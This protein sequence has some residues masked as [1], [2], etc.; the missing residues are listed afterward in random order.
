[1]V[2][3][4]YTEQITI[5]R[6]L[7][8]LG[9]GETTTTIK[10]PAA[11]RAGSVTHDGETYDYIVDAYPS[12]GTIDVRIEGF[13]LVANGENK[14][15]GTTRFA[16]VF[17]R[18]IHG[19]SA[20]LYS[21]TVKNFAGTPDYESW[22]IVI[23][24]DSDLSIDDNDVSGF[25]RDGIDAI[26]D[27]GA[28]ADPNVIISHNT[29]IGSAAPLNGIYI[30]RGATGTISGNTVTDLT[31][32]S[33]WAA[34][35]ILIYNSD[36]ITVNDSNHVEN[37]HY[38]LDLL[39]SDGSTVSGN[40]LQDNVAFHIGLDN[41]DNNEVSGNTITGTLA[42]TEDKA[43]GL[44]NGSTGNTIGGPTPADGNS[45]TMAAIPE[46]FSPRKY[47]Y[48]VY[49]VGSVG[50]GNNTIQYNNLYGGTRAVQIDGG[51][52]GITTISDNTI[53]NISP[54]FAGIYLNGGSAIISRN[55]L[56]NT[57]R[58]MEWWG[59][60][61]V[62]V[63]NN[64]IDGATFDGINCGTF[65]GSITI[66][67]NA[68]YS[69]TGLGVH[70]RTATLIDASGNW[71]G[72]STPAGVAAEVSAN[73][74][75]TPWLGIGTDTD[76][77]TP[78]FQGDLSTLWVDDSSPQAGAMGR[79]E[80]G[81]S[82]VTSSTVYIAPGIYN[83][84]IT[85]DDSTP[86]DLTLV[87]SDPGNRPEI[88]GGVLFD[89]DTNDLNSITLRS[90]VLKGDADPSTR[91]AIIDMNN[92]AAVNDFVMDN[93]LLD[94]ENVAVNPNGADGRFGIVGNKFGGSFSIT[95]SEFKN[96]LGWVVMDMDAAYS[97]PPVG[98][99]ELPL[100]TVTF[101]D[102]SVH[103][104]NGSV[105]LRGNHASKTS[106]VNAN[107]NIWDN[108]GGNGGQTGIHWAALEV[109]NAVQ[110]NVQDN[111]IGNVQQGDYGEGQALQF[112]NVDVLNVQGNSITNNY[113]GIYI[114]SDGVGG[115]YCGASGCPVPGGFISG[116]D[117]MGN[118]DYGVK[119][120]AAAAG[121]PLN[122]ELN[123]WGHY[124]GPY[125]PTLN[126]GGIGNSVSDNVDFIPWDCYDYP[127]LII[128]LDTELFEDRDGGGGNLNVLDVNG[129]GV[130]GPGDVLLG[131][132]LIEN[133]GGGAATGV[134]YSGI[135]ENTTVVVGTVITTQGAVTSGNSPG[136]TIVVVDV[137]TIPGGG[138]VLITYQV[139][140]D[141]PLPPGVTIITHQGV[142]SS[143]EF[144]DMPPEDV[145]TSDGVTSI[146]IGEPL[147]HAYISPEMSI[148]KPDSQFQVCIEVDSATA[149][150]EIIFVYALLTFDSI[151][152]DSVK[153]PLFGTLLDSSGWDIQW[154]YV[155]GILDTLELWLVGGGTEPLT[156]A[157][158]LVCWEFRVRDVSPPGDTTSIRFSKFWFNEGTPLV[159]TENGFFTVNR[160]PE[161]ITGFDDTT[162]LIEK[163]EYC[164]DIEAFD[165]DGDSLI[166]WS[167][168]DPYPCDGA[169]PD[170]AYGRGTV[171][172][173][174]CWTPPKPGTCDTLQDTLIVM[175]TFETG[176]PLYDT[177]TTT[178]VVLDNLVDVWWPD[179]V[180]HACGCIEVPLY[181]MHNREYNECLDSLD[182][183][184]F[185]LILDYDPELLTVLGVHN[186]GL[187]TENWGAMQYNVVEEMI[188][189]GMS[190]N[191]PLS[192]CDTVPPPIIYVEFCLDG[193]AEVGDSSVLSVD[194][195]KLNEGWPTVYW[196][197]GSIHVVDYTISGTV[198]YC[199]IGLPIPEVEVKISYEWPAGTYVD[200]VFT[201]TLGFYEI[202]EIQGCTEYCLTPQKHNLPGQ[203]IT[204]YDA[205]L[206]LR[207]MV[208]LF[209]LNSCDSIAA[210]VSQDGTISGYDA[211]LLLR[212]VVCDNCG[213][214]PRAHAGEWIFLPDHRCYDDLDSNAFDQDYVGIIIGDV[215]Q[216]YPGDG[217][218]KIV[219][220]DG[221]RVLKSEVTVSQGD[222]ITLPILVDDGQE[223]YSADISVQYDPQLLTALGVDTTSLTT[224]FMSACDIR[225][226]LV[227]IG[228][229]GTEPL[230]GNGLLA[231]ILF[232]VLP[233]VREGAK[234]P[235][236]LT[237]WLNERVVPEVI[238]VGMVTAGRLIP[239]VFDL[240]QNYPNPFNPVTTIDFA[241]PREA[242]SACDGL[243]QVKLN[244]YN[245]LGQEVNTLVNELVEPGY[246]TVRWNGRD[247][248]GREMASGIYFYRMTAGAFSSTRSMVLLK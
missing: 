81:L 139:V 76:P 151:L 162:H 43:I 154:R 141:D 21:C 155:S 243:S 201:D 170:T 219:A 221:C 83:E 4:T 164:A 194:H 159:E 52:T 40:I 198:T 39:Q 50:S 166:M 42:G 211:S 15:A 36:G 46:T 217:P 245:M 222:T 93:C 49:L 131:N 143:N 206:L 13:T 158:S 163:H 109:N 160:P 165:P 189:V 121:G 247:E 223:I 45:I 238:S 7:D 75:Y 14:S 88:T 57:V 22:G 95:N 66:S 68:I 239:D 27:D 69:T 140:I 114:Y 90:L 47:I 233:G 94:G 113:Q 24:E 195:V 97:A 54:T 169:E 148:A 231:E 229:A 185:D 63:Y 32:S 118:T 204:S 110:V 58:P 6:S 216:N 96:I 111:S 152:L 30:G 173:E 117:I 161:F 202:T 210:D 62:T 104:C 41:S 17:F 153:V 34:V 168:L 197:N 18:D 3:G 240:A 224:G 16:G 1:M 56:T 9:A 132:V 179:T 225:D 205:S 246:Y 2:A 20:G 176:Q 23:Y 157:G 19:A 136:D 101:S 5:G 123:C 232:S 133:I 130:V 181:I 172:M 37:C 184:S 87:A 145:H 98:G 192:Y 33:P 147:I 227:R 171:T 112:W 137:G 72:I 92:S 73:V 248:N 64:I 135:Y 102:N 209:S 242:G 167:L 65:S 80:E 150:M 84:T 78:G 12:S 236:E 180:W 77:G 190:G 11:D 28:G 134:V 85:L 207:S 183:M 215:S 119:V 103:D 191:Y 100:T 175:S 178:F 142:V 234:I 200:T 29:V 235:F 218:P 149:E 208:G 237:V 144:G 107:R 35:G 53:G 25:T 71:W 226:G 129:D 115:S 70:N 174:W 120:E 31:R 59:P 126:P 122:A 244:V 146:V 241:V 230:R 213:D 214:D 177:L 8:L 124:T 61:N 220:S 26:G 67:N 108:I 203:V 106:T 116:N 74:D 60:N 128:T 51:N 193:N 125:H 79:I 55:R 99:N 82:I 196:E 10:A 182:I 44:S 127:N 156:G 86:D 199:D 48:V 212:S 228:L 186:R 38:G 187:I 188:Y 105:A 138:T 89:N 91:E